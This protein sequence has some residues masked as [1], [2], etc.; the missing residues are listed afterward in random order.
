[1]DIPLVNLVLTALE[2][3]LGKPSAP[4]AL[5]E[6]SFKGREWDYVKECIDS[7]VRF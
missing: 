6:P 5:H 7:G 4:I 2:T 3:V 1:M